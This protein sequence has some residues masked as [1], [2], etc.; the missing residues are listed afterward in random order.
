MCYR[1]GYG[2]CSCSQEDSKNK[3]CEK[4]NYKGMTHQDFQEAVKVLG[5][6]CDMLEDEEDI[7]EEEPILMIG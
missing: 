1:N 5:A 6:I 7:C 3:K 2:C 4:E